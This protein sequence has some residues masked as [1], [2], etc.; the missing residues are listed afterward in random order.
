MHPD[1]SVCLS[2]VLSGA[3]TFGLVSAGDQPRLSLPPRICTGR[4]SSFGIVAPVI[5][6][7]FGVTSAY[8]S[9][10]SFAACIW[11]RTHWVG[12]TIFFEVRFHKQILTLLQPGLRSQ[13]ILVMTALLKKSCS[14]GS[15]ITGICLLMICNLTN[16]RHG[17]H[18]KDGL[19]DLLSGGYQPPDSGQIKDILRSFT[20][21]QLAC[22]DSTQVFLQASQSL[23]KLCSF[24]ICITFQIT[25]VPIFIGI[26]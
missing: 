16:A 13:H 4:F 19:D 18:F 2:M 15:A 11:S 24:T 10:I 22:H 5:K 26:P 3:G 25:Q 14:L 7:P 21:C 20:K 17:L 8:M 9:G 6:H 12:K 1:R 23:L